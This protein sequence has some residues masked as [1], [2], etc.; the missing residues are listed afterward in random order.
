MADIVLG[1]DNISWQT[2]LQSSI[3]VP[4]HLDGNAA[5]LIP[6]CREESL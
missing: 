3:T 1:K 6:V 4:F 5:L 2:F